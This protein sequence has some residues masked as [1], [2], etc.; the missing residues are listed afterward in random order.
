M[1]IPCTVYR[2]G[3]LIRQA[4]TM[5][6]LCLWHV[7]VHVHADNVHGRRVHH[8]RPGR[9]QRRPVLWRQL[10]GAGAGHRTA[11]GRQATGLAQARGCG[12]LQ[13]GHAARCQ[14]NAE[15]PFCLFFYSGLRGHALKAARLVNYARRWGSR[16]LSCAYG[17]GPWCPWLASVQ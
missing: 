10:L 12:A 4:N 17:L 7:H 2:G 14:H 13:G 11:G 9:R 6:W 15:I 8:L 3:T 16:L 5:A 1:G